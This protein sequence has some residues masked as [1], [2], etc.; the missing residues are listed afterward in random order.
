MLSDLPAEMQREVIENGAG[1]NPGMAH[2]DDIVCCVKMRASSRSLA[3]APVLALPHDMLQRTGMSFLPASL[4][5]KNEIPLKH[6]LGWLDLAS[7]LVE[8]WGSGFERAVKYIV[9]LASGSVYD[10]CMASALRY[11]SQPRVAVPIQL[12]LAVV[13]AVMPQVVF[14]ANIRR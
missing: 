14:R 6:K 12:P 3:Q 9:S 11:H 5:G 10:G 1:W 2:A 7:A 4:R 8:V 13:S